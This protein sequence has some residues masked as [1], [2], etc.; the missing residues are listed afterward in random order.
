M[1]RRWR[2]CSTTAE[3]SLGALELFLL[4]CPPADIV[5]RI[6]VPYCEKQNQIKHCQYLLCVQHM[7]I[8]RLMQVNVEAPSEH[9][10]SSSTV[11]SINVYSFHRSALLYKV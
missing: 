9:V 6:P 4:F 10:C 5:V 3:G 1:E 11:E 2:V 8:N 7:R